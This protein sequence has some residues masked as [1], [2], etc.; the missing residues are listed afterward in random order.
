MSSTLLFPHAN[1][2]VIGPAVIKHAHVMIEEGKL[3]KMIYEI[4]DNN[5]DYDL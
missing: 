1:S 2:F 5:F 3:L 4:Y